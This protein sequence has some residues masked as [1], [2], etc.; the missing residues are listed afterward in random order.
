MEEKLKFRTLLEY[1]TPHKE[2]P[3]H[4]LMWKANITDEL[5]KRYNWERPTSCPC[6]HLQNCNKEIR[7]IKFPKWCSTCLFFL[8]CDICRIRTSSNK[9]LNDRCSHYIEVDFDTWHEYWG[10]GLDNTEE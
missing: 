9:R 8:F 4:C 2:I 7:E 1:I 5:L 6:D 10:V 3:D